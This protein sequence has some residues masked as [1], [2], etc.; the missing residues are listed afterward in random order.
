MAEKVE[1]ATLKRTLFAILMA[2]SIFML[3]CGENQTKLIR[4]SQLNSL[5]TPLKTYL[6]ELNKTA[7]FQDAS[8]LGSFLYYYEWYK[9]KAPK[10]RLAFRGLGLIVLLLSV[11]LPVIVAAEEKIPKRKAVVIFISLAIALSTGINS[12]YRF[13]S[14]WKG[15]ITA[16]L[17]LEYERNIWEAEIAKASAMVD[18]TDQV[19]SATLSTE[20]FINRTNDIIR[21]ETTGF[22]EVQKMPKNK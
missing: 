14:S 13:D 12:F 5:D 16:Q 8:T 2:I 11:L 18:P 7:F 4:S 10:H 20:N 22:F 21:Q 3:A 15:Y 6:Q 9:S 17:Q 19:K 1:G